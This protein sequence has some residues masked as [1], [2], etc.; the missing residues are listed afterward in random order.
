MKRR[1]PRKIWLLAGVALIAVGIAL[2]AVQARGEW[3]AQR[4]AV[5]EGFQTPESVAV[6]PASG[7]A[8]VS[9]VVAGEAPEGQ[10]P[11]WFEDGQGFISRLKPDGTIDV[12]KWRE[13]TAQGPLNAPKGL[14]I[15]GRKLRAA[16]ITRMATFGL[17]NADNDQ[18][19]V[20]RGA[21]NLNDMATDGVA[22]YISDTGT[23][24]VHRLAPGEHRV[25]QGPKAVNGVTCFRGKLFAVSWA[26]HE[27]YQLDP[28]GRAAPKSFALA[29]HFKSLDGIEVLDDGT[30]VVA[31]FPGNKVST[32]SADG[33]TV[34]TL[35][36]TKSPADIGLDRRRLLLYVPLF[37]ENRVEVYQLKKR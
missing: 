4:V 8:Y 3:T 14:C 28:S 1:M 15:L 37:T 31:D 18:A 17:D 35:I 20:I 22:V 30:F 24:N 12:L 27:V 25:I 13:R 16:D 2:L 11:Y 6:E 26:L 10:S 9:N 29:D 23:G 32:I 19:T 21:K 34:R 36:E 7:V 5:I 33:K